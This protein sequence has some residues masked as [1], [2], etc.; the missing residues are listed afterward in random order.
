MEPLSDL[1]IFCAVVEQGSL[2]KAG[3]R[4]RLS[5][6]VISRRLI[7]LEARLGVRL[8]QRTTR[9][10]ALT[11]EG[12][13][14]YQRGRAVL[15]ELAETEALL[16][17]RQHQPSGVLKVTA[18]ASFGRQHLA[19]HLPAFLERYPQLEVHLLL[20]DAVLDLVD[21]A[22]DL[23][24]RI[25]QPDKPGLVARPLCVNRRI[26][27]AAPGY[28]DRQGEPR[29]PAELA[30][31]NCL[32]LDEVGT[33]SQVWSLDG[34]QGPS[35]VEV[36]GNLVSNLGDAVG[37]ACLAGGGIAI[38]STW[39][40]SDA[41]R[42]GRVRQVLPGYALPAQEVLA[43]Y[44]S[45]R[46]LSPKVRVLIDFLLQTFGDPPYWDQQLDAQ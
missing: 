39:A 18:S 17:A 12:E 29:H 5:S 42:A 24:I 19:P 44:P 22:L 1:H 27:C 28:L 7:N 43:I 13:L 14:Y 11:P 25:G 9:R 33:R 8:L 2:V 45:R 26:L 34:P 36:R 32:L 20:S 4:L 10:Q 21:G 35:E 3:E 15:D 37:E 38:R 46:H 6:A 23:A 30:R 16:M 40:V 41:L 31:H